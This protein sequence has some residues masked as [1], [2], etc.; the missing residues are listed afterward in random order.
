MKLKADIG[1][2]IGYFESSR[3]FRIYNRQTKK[4]TETVHVK[5]D[6]LTTMASEC[7]NLEHG[8]N[9]MNFQDSSEYSLLVPSKSDLN[10]LF[11]P[12]YEE[13]YEISS[14]EVLDNSAANTLDNDNTSSSLSIVVE[15]DEDPQIVSSS[16]DQVATEPNSPVLNENTDELVQ[17][18]VVD[19]DGN[20]F[21]NAPPT[22]VF[23]EAE[24]SSI[25]QDL[26][27]MHEFHQKHRLSD[28]WTT[29]HPIKQVIGDPSKPELVECLIGR[30]IIA[31]KWIWR[32]KIDAKNTVIQK[33]SRLVSKGYR[34]E[35]GI[36]FEES[37]A[38]VARLEAVRIFVAYAA[39]KNFP[40]YQMDVK[41]AFLNGPLKEEFFVRQPDGFV[42]PN[43]LNHVYRLKK[44]LYGLKQSPRAW[45]DKLSSFLIEHHFTK[46]A[47]HAGRN[48][49]CKNTSGGSQFLGDKLV[50]WSSKKQDCIAMLTAK[51]EYISLSARCAQ[52]HV[53]KGTI[54][55]YFVGMEYQ[56]ADLFTK[57]LLK[58][59]FEYLVHMIGMRCMTPTQLERLAK[60]IPCSPECKI[61]GQI[62]L[63]HP[64]SYALTATADVLVD[65][66][67]NVN[68]KKEAIQYP[69]FI[70]LIIA[71][72][73]KKFPE[74]PQRIEEDYHSIKDD[75][76]LVSV[77]TTGNVLVRGMLIPNAF[78]TKEIHAI[79]DFKEST[80]RAHR[81]L[82]LTASPQRK[83]RKHTT[84]ESSSPQKSLKITIRQQK[85]I[86]EEKD[87]DDSENGLEPGSHKDNPETMIR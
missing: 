20:M 17:E 37:F 68:Q 56:L 41:T 27:N 66:M 32:N 42:D 50:S 78:L 13:Y 77:Y 51:A 1:I 14:P 76:P 85:L 36:D 34:Q 58:E 11:G 83:K 40:I 80:P 44:A 65:F 84:R 60:S 23:K 86:E 82:T 70:K 79:D 31:V 15:E 33:K 63:D 57:G 30:N 4:I 16:S 35:E 39:H 71:D 67:N 73:M 59:R 43:F 9:C 7:N 28:R 6:E 48:D 22:P 29:N 45:Y 8:M 64:L 10:N 26:S 55:I 52:E 62:L 74:I 75:I 12:L 47:D 18:D 87:D 61:V 38:L 81:T 54:E 5:F 3:G 24:S 69:R 21:Y 46:D 72:L 19:F 25:Y 49:D 2:F 53:E